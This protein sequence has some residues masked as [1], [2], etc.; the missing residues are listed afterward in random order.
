MR[1]GA[2]GGP[3]EPVRR[4]RTRVRAAPPRRFADAFSFNR[5]T[6]AYSRRAICNLFWSAHVPRTD[7]RS[8]ITPPGEAAGARVIDANVPRLRAHGAPKGALSF[9]MPSLT[10]IH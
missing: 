5:Q 8:A 6:C 1:F 4:R 9:F 7:C 3:R 10:P 2:C